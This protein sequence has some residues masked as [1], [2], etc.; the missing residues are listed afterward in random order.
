[1][2]NKI[3]KG[4]SI[5]TLGLMIIALAGCEDKKQLKMETSDNVIKKAIEAK[6]KNDIGSA[7]DYVEVEINSLLSEFYDKKYMNQNT[8]DTVLE[9]IQKEI[10]KGKQ[11]RDK[12]YLTINESFI[13]VYT[14][15]TKTEEVVSGKINNKGIITWNN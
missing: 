9:Y 13:V 15:N 6:K 1:M 14:D 8:S 12:I 5:I 3:L 11:L 10:G 7:K 2:K 4:I